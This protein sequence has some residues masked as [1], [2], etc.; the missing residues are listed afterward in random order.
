MKCLRF[1]CTISVLKCITRQLI[2][3]EENKKIKKQRF[4]SISLSF[5]EC[6][7][8]DQC[9]KIRQMP[10]QF[11]NKDIHLLFKKQLKE[12]IKRNYLF[13]KP[14]LSIEDNFI[15]TFKPYLDKMEEKINAKKIKD[16]G[17]TIRKTRINRLFKK[18]WNRTGNESSIST[19]IRA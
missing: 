8:Y 15:D 17:A 18:Q 12:I 1:N 6:G 2:A 13:K 14:Y 11:I 4:S 3:E 16:T 19:S 5:C 7:K 10:E 9:K